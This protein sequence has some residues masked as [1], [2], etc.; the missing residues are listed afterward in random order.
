MQR[1][2]EQ[3]QS[4]L[5]A[6]E[7]DVSAG[8]GAV[9]VKVTASGKFVSLVLDPEF[10]KEDAKTVSD[11]ILSAVQ[12]AAKQAKELHDGE[13]QKVTASLQMPGMF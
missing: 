13:M 1:S 10:L 8:G 3:L 5:D 2:I 6:K 11:T 9:K 12:D 7:L 4:Q